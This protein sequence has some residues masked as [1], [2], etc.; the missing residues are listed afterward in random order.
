MVYYL[1]GYTS[2]LFLVYCLIVSYDNEIDPT[3]LLA[4]VFDNP[5]V[6]P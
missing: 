3:Y 1:S 4:L 6:L 5:T 2:F